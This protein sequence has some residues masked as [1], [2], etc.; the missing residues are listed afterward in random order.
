MDAPWDRRFK[1]RP[2]RHR[3]LNEPTG[4]VIAPDNARIVNLNCRLHE[5]MAFGF[6]EVPKQDGS[7]R[8]ADGA[9][10]RRTKCPPGKT[11]RR[12]IRRRCDNRDLDVEADLVSFQRRQVESL[13]DPTS[14]R[15]LLLRT[16]RTDA[17]VESSSRPKI[18]SG[19][20]RIL[21]CG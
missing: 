4:G 16:R 21:R 3:V 8:V 5:L 1:L 20:L 15:S 17:G 14:R 9:V 6:V 10:T 7:P 2:H 13:A 18:A 19:Y 11:G 12:L